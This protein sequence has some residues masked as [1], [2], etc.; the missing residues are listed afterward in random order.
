M[1]T[2]STSF[3][4]KPQQVGSI[5]YDRSQ[6]VSLLA[7]LNSKLLRKVSGLKNGMD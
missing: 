2:K 7:I 5:K 6:E 1:E 4:D 3:I